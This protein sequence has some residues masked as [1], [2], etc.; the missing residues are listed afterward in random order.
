[1]RILLIVGSEINSNSSYIA[2]QIIKNYSNVEMKILNL[3]N[4]SMQFCNGCLSC[5]ETGKCILID[6]MS[7]I[8]ENVSNYDGYIFIS[9]VRWSLLSGYMKTFFDRLNPLATTAKLSGKKSISIVIG[10]SKHNEP[11]AESVVLAS[12]SIQF[13]C[14]NAEIEVVDSVEIYNCLMHGDIENLHNDLA[15]CMSSVQKLITSLN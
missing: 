6:D 7:S 12:K 2:N 5:D 15:R 14:E 10:Q 1:M 13:F 11:G 4:I 9:P 8:V 3:S